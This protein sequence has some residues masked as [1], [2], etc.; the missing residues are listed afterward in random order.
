MYLGLL[1]AVAGGTVKHKSPNAS[2]ALIS[3]GLGNLVLPPP[4]SLSWVPLVEVVVK[5]AQVL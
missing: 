3:V 5:L 1:P 4:P 2:L